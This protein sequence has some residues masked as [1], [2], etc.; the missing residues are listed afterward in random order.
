MSG[1]PAPSSL[2]PPVALG[3][4]AAAAFVGLVVLAIVM[5]V[6]FLDSGA[7]AGQV[8]LDPIASYGV[9]SVTRLAD[10]GL[11]VVRLRGTEILALGDLDAA[12]RATMD[13]RCRVA[14]IATDDP[15][16]PGLVVRYA[17]SFSPAAAGGSLIFREDCNGALYDATGVRLDSEAPNLD[18]Y[19]TAI[20]DDG[21]LVVNTARRLCT[22]RAGVERYVEVSCSK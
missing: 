3:C 11:Y 16:L 20:S 8:T 10:R 15:D 2:R 14:P 12:N 22:Q 21:R 19:P 9:G 7:D 18:R 4:T 5:A 6:I 17:N 1:T 13:R